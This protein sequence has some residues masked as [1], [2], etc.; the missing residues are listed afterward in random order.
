MTAFLTGVSTQF[1]F[2]A[3]EAQRRRKKS[4]NLLIYNSLRL[5]VFA[6]VFSFATSIFKY[7]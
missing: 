1:Y 6:V 4:L 7:S 5:R 2:F 3:A